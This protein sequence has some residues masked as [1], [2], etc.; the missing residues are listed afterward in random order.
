MSE[1][2]LEDSA[3]KRKAFVKITGKDTGLWDCPGKGLRVWVH[4]GPPLWW[5]GQQKGG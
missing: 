1:I 4:M 2:N 5:C 3:L